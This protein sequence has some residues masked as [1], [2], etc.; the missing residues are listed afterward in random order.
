MRREPIPRTRLA[1]LIVASSLAAA[2]ARP[3]Q[4]QEGRSPLSRVTSES[5]ARPSNGPG[6]LARGVPP[7]ATPAIQSGADEG[8]RSTLRL[9]K[10]G[11]LAVSA[12]ASLYGFQVHGR[13]DDEFQSLERI[14]EADPGRCQTRNADGSFADPDLE[15][16]YQRVLDRDGSARAALIL[17]QV[18][19]AAT[20]VLFI[21][22]LG[23]NE[24]PP[25][26]PFEPPR[27]RVTPDGVTEV[28]YS[29]A[30]PFH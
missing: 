21:M 3:L 9:I 22:D 20:I 8:G 14:C 12:G 24:T 6:W 2:G 27:M 13:A 11:T 25:D 16:R 23:G 1:A 10:W 4:A 29:V 7:A 28:S 26:I 19:L 15:A 17:A 18:G 5:E 30:L